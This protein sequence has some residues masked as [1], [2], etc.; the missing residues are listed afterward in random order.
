MAKQHR[1]NGYIADQDIELR[2]PEKVGNVSDDLTQKRDSPSCTHRA[3]R[4]DVS[5]WERWYYRMGQ[6]E[7][8]Y[9]IYIRV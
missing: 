5:V 4:Y 6:K 2:P 3:E 7:V 9:A 8:Y 1:R